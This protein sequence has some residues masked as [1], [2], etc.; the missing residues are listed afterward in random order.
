MDCE[1]LRGFLVDPGEPPKDDELAGVLGECLT[2]LVGCCRCLEVVRSTMLGP[3]GEEV[4]SL[5][6]QAVRRATALFEGVGKRFHAMSCADAI[7]RLL[8]MGNEPYQRDYAGAVHYHA[9]TCQEGC[10]NL[11]LLLRDCGSNVIAVISRLLALAEGDA[12]RAMLYL[13]PRRLERAGRRARFDPPIEDDD[14]H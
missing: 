9:L 3:A 10:F 5:Q 13:D 11:W 4:H 8:A 7:K 14:I 12:S 1:G 2:H 6:H